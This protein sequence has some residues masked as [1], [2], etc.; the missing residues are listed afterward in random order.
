M[1]GKEQP[2]FMSEEDLYEPIKL[3]GTHES[4]LTR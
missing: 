4:T 2:E 3:S 1:A